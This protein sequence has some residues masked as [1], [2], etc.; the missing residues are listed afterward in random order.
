MNGCPLCSRT[1]EPAR[2]GDPMCADH[3]AM[4]AT[5]RRREAATAPR[6]KKVTV[7]ECVE[8]HGSGISFAR[9]AGGNGDTVL[10]DV[11]HGEGRVAL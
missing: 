4:M 9:V 3:R 7:A 10:C 1:L 8:C 11:C 6:V 2:I 5:N